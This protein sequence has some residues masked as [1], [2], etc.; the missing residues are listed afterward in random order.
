MNLNILP[1]IDT[2]NAIRPKVTSTKIVPALITVIEYRKK[3]NYLSYIKLE[4]KDI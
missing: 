1:Y 2:R 3:D 4:Y